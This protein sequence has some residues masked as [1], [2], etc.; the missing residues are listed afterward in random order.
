MKRFL[1]VGLMT[2]SLVVNAQDKK[3]NIDPKYAFCYKQTTLE[4][5]DYKIYIDDAVNENTYSKFKIDI[6]LFILCVNY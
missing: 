5:D 6:F 4:T 2:L 3:K 1:I